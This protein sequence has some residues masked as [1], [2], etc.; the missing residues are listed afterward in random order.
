M[1]RKI[2]VIAIPVVIIVGA[3]GGVTVLGKLKPEPEKRDEPPSGL[4]VFVEE[5]HSEDVRLSITTQGEVIPRREIS[6]IPQV[7]GR[8]VYV[9]D[10]FI[11]GGFFERG[12]TL[13]RV[14]QADYR[15]ALTRAEA[16]V[17]RA[18][19]RLTREQAEAELARAEWEEI[20]EGPA[21]PLTLREPQMAEARADLA[22]AEAALRDAELA[23]SR[24][25]ISAPFAGRVRSRSADLGQYITP[26]QPVATV[27]SSEA[28][29]VR[30][31]LTNNQLS[32]IDMPLAFEAT[33][34]EVGPQVRFSAN[35]AGERHDWTG[36]IVRTDAAIDPQT[37][38]LYAIAE[39]QDPYGTG[40]DDGVP[41]SVGLFVDAAIDGRAVS[42][43]VI[44]P[45][46]ALRNRSDVFVA[47]DDDTLDIR[48]AQVINSNTD[49]AIL[50]GGI[51]PGERVIVSP[52]QTPS[53]GMTLRPLTVAEEERGADAALAAAAYDA[54]TGVQE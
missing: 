48:T 31:P 27:F 19:Q 53:Q 22:A 23:L 35:V 37:R 24:T 33:G 4:A 25:S 30:L 1:L 49:R 50:A 13:L 10:S 40:S 28:V 26:G 9:N 6:L 32:M 18:Q 20:G 51:N 46:A 43:A 42:D 8:V 34:E 15:L 5:A 14:E 36:H 44:I 41:M 2:L 52:I 54:D 7:S 11:E 3:F 39:V 47:S 45:R 21:S 29:Q 16:E 38:V 17:A 12:E